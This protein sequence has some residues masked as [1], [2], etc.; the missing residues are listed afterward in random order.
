MPALGRE[1]KLRIS[2]G[3]SPNATGMHFIYF[4]PTLFD[5]AGFSRAYKRICGFIFMFF[6]FSYDRKFGFFYIN[7]NS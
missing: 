5:T 7:I 4:I 3:L 6:W 2:E 1:Y